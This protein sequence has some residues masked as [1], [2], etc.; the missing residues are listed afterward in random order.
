MYSKFRELKGCN[1]DNAIKDGKSFACIIECC[2]NKR[3]KEIFISKEL[4][5]S[6]FINL[7]D[8]LEC[9]FEFEKDSIN[10]HDLENLF[11]NKTQL[12]K[13]FLKIAL[14]NIYFGH[15]MQTLI[16]EFV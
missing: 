2:E 12:V 1:L 10:E 4:H 9:S 5:A 14:M 13:I 11:K 3:L 8:I 16:K 6:K 7:N 15:T